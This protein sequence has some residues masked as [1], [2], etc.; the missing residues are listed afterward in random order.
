MGT[1]R[2]E[3]NEGVV[4]MANRGYVHMMGLMLI[5]F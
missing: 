1:L 4:N 5:C 2:G 3:P